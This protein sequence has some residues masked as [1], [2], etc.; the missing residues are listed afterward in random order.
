MVPSDCAKQLPAMHRETSRAV[1]LRMNW[2]CIVAPA[3]VE[4]RSLRRRSVQCQGADD[5]RDP[6]PL[7][8]LEVIEDSLAAEETVIRACSAAAK[9]DKL[10]CRRGQ[11]SC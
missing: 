11:F 5:G 10:H 3:S 6:S 9:R 1:V 7:I 8:E 4:C 2:D